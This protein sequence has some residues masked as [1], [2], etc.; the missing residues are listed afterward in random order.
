[1]P[2]VVTFPEV[3]TEL[4]PCLPMKPSPVGAAMMAVSEAT[5][6]AMAKVVLMLKYKKEIIRSYS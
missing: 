4:I 6:V 1:L 3:G 5:S 2:S